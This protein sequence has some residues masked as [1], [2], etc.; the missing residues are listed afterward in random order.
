MSGVVLRCPNCGTTRGTPGECEACHEAQVRYFCTNHTPGR[1]LDGPAC[2]QCGAAF[3]EPAGPRAPAPA[4]AA[5]TRLPPSARRPARPPA[6]IA[7]PRPPHR[8]SEG[9]GA[10]PTRGSGRSPPPPDDVFGRRDDHP[11]GPPSLEE[12]LRDVLRGRPIPPPEPRRE[13]VRSRGLGLGGCLLRLM[14][15]VFAFFLALIGGLFG[16]WFRIW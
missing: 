14:L 6:T 10:G 5:P 16:P 7:R 3:G 1:W 12:I 4:P 8:S 15:M 13:R 2:T 9:P 11:A